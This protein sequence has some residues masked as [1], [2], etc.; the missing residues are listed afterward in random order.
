MPLAPPEFEPPGWPVVEP[1][2][3]MGYVGNVLVIR[4]GGGLPD[5][6]F[7]RYM[8]EWDR[9]VDARPPDAA[10]FAMYDIPEWP[11]MTAVQ[12]R[13]WS[14]ML[15]SREEM[16][17]R[18]TRGMVLASPSVLTRGAA[19]AIL[20]RAASLSVRGG[21]HTP[22]GLRPHRA[23]GR[24]AGRAVSAGVRGLREGPVARPL[25]PGYTRADPCWRT[26]SLLA[27]RRW[28]AP[29]GTQRW[30]SACARLLDRARKA[31]TFGVSAGQLAALGGALVAVGSIVQ[32]G[33]TDRG[34]WV[35]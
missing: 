17:R 25:T 12:R 26:A 7:R 13:D 11:G 22:R 33:F 27:R 35:R 24:S 21:R 16:L 20:A 31:L 3:L 15:K 1:D 10:V 28:R 8:E 30:Y 14:A 2:L 18:T 32:T 29:R 19:R 9:A 6:S 5:A 34:C 23:A 4:I